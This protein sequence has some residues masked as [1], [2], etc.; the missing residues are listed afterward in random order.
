LLL[1]I[2]PYTHSSHFY[3]LTTFVVVALF[4]FYNLPTL[5][6]L[7]NLTNSCYYRAPPPSRANKKKTKKEKK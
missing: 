3:K 7:C 6:T 5:K 1:Y 2:I 4:F